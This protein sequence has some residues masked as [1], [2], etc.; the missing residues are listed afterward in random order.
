MYLHI[1]YIHTHTH[2]YIYICN[3]WVRYI[4]SPFI[5]PDAVS[6][7]PASCEGISMNQRTFRKKWAAVNIAIHESISLA[8]IYAYLYIYVYMCMYMY[9][10]TC[11]C[12][13]LCIYVYIYIYMDR[14]YIPVFICFLVSLSNDM[15]AA[16]IA[17]LAIDQIR[18]VSVK[19]SAHI[20]ADERCPYYSTILLEPALLPSLPISF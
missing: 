9:M 13:Y 18:Q 14:R 15:R 6:F 19:W 17:T 16:N 12:M 4:Y 11:L 3:S 8:L 5:D 7:W 10:Y 20:G 1:R 2:I